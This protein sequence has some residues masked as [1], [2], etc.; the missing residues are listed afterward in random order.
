MTTGMSADWKL[1]ASRY[2]GHTSGVWRCE[3][4]RMRE[5]DEIFGFAV[6]VDGKQHSIASAGVYE[7]ATLIIGAEYRHLPTAAEFYTP[8][9]VE[10]NA[11]LIAD[12]P[13]LLAECLRLQ[14]ECALLRGAFIDYAS[15][16]LLDEVSDPAICMDGY[17]HRDTVTLF[18]AF[19]ID[20]DQPCVAIR[21]A[22]AALSE[23]QGETK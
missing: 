4:A 9:E 20:T 17:H 22:R 23:K 14:A 6:E 18:N 15:K 5:G 19:G 8:A 7:D 10:A 3:P 12:A 21:A 2:A 16:Y 11:R 1:D 13:N